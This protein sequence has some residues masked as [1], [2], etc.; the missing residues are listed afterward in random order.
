MVQKSKKGGKVKCSDCGRILLVKD[1][2]LKWDKCQVCEAII[3]VNCM[4]YN[5]VRKEGLYNYYYVVRVCRNH[6]I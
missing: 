1:Q 6:M 5:R 2:G 3:C 4:W